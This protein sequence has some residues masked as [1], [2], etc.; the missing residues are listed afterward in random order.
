MDPSSEFIDNS[1]VMFLKVL[2][3]IGVS[4]V[5]LAG[6]DGYNDKESNYFDSSKE[7]DF[8]KS[9]AWYLNGYT[10]NFMESICDKISFDFL[11]DTKYL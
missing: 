7:Y 11:T 5:T 4:K 10:K 8:V 3:N 1:F 9:K 6:F 2:I